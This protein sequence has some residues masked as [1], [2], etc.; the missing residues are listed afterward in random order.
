VV[1]RTK[2]VKNAD[3]EDVE[4]WLTALEN[5]KLSDFNIR[6]PYLLRAIGRAQTD[7]E[8]VKKEGSVTRPQDFR[9]AE[10]NVIYAVST[11]LDRGETWYGVA[12]TLGISNA[13]AK[14][15]FG[16]EVERLKVEREQIAEDQAAD[17]G[18]MLDQDQDYDDGEYDPPYSVPYEDLSKED[19]LAVGRLADAVAAFK[20]VDT[21]QVREGGYVTVENDYDAQYRDRV[22]RVAM[23]A[24]GQLER[25]LL[26]GPPNHWV[27]FSSGAGWRVTD[28]EP[29]LY[30]RGWVGWATVQTEENVTERVFGMWCTVK[31]GTQER[32]DF[33]TSENGQRYITRDVHGFD[34]VNLLHPGPLENFH[35]AAGAWLYDF[36]NTPDDPDY[37]QAS[38]STK[39][40]YYNWANGLIDLLK[41]K[42]S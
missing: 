42:L 17:L 34:R 7:L 29:P 13:E 27:S 23:N 1:K 32:L 11:A 15:R 41:S 14:E 25:L 20:P 16:D 12:R 10:W 38:P 30:Q 28:Y 37:E 18:S 4:T 3:I 5:G 36:S 35:Q 8:L 39:N 33:V 40:Q 31:F 6:D 26:A 9:K 24:D 22:L 21:S 2:R 19:K